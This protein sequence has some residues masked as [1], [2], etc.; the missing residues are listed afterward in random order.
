MVCDGINHC[1]DNSD[2]QNCGA[3]GKPNIV[4]GAEDA[5]G[6]EP[7]KYQCLSDPT[8]CLDIVVRCNGSAECPRGEDEANCSGCRKTEFE[9]SN[10]K[11]ILSEWHCDKEDDCGDKSDERN[12]SYEHEPIHSC[13]THMFNCKDGNCIPSAHVCDGKKDCPSGLD[14]SG[15]C[16]KSCTTAFCQH[17]CHPT[18]YGPICAC[19]A[20]YTLAPDE[21]K[22][23]DID[24]CRELNPC[25]QKCENTVGSYECSCYSEFMLKTDKLTCKADGRTKF[26]LFSS[27]NVIYN[28]TAMSLGEV[29]SSENSAIVGLD[30]NVE[31]KLIYFTMAD[32]RTIFEYSIDSK[33]VTFITDIGN[34]K[35]VAVDWITNNV[36]FVDRQS[37]PSIRICHMAERICIRLLQF[38]QK[39]IVETL[40]VDPVNNKL[41]YTNLHFIVYSSPTAVIYSTNLDGTHSNVLVHSDSHVTD[42]VCDPNKKIL[43]YV[44]L[45]ANAVRSVNYD[46]S[47]RR[48]IV[49]ENPMV[50]K[51]ISIS[52]YE[53]ELTILNVGT[54]MAAKCLVYGKKECRSYT[55]NAY[56]AENVVIVQQSR[57]KPVINVCAE[58]NCSMICVAA[59]RGPKCLCTGGTFVDPGVQ[60]HDITVSLYVIINCMGNNAIYLFSDK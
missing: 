59:E 24:E 3:N 41:F 29:W 30:V 42:I 22:C 31:K 18:P 14:E 47:D 35:K 4:C 26:M 44:E 17:L 36:Y 25:A 32:S 45:N 16:N 57:Q 39:D 2:E 23:L 60:C 51:P 19:K 40:A 56:N 46:G 10:G 48:T 7:T 37:A 53:D 55:L 58:N 11:C 5:E 54:N 27:S 38:H 8:M 50:N 9:C 34:P 12:C 28:V 13:P 20:G 21:R 1:G 33:Q 43:Y 6:K 52:L 15:K 49:K